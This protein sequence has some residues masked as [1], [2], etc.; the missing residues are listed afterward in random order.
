MGAVVSTCVPRETKEKEQALPYSP[1]PA[2]LLTKKSSDL[3]GVPFETP[4]KA[5]KRL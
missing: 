1:P 5:L 4:E 3:L 2:S